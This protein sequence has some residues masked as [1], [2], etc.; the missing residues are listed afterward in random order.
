MKR[1]ALP[2]ILLL[3]LLLVLVLIAAEGDREKRDKDRTVTIWLVRHAETTANARNI[4][5]GSGGDAP[6]SAHGMEQARAAGDLLSEVSFDSVYTS[7]SRRTRQT[8]DLI[9]SRN[10]KE[11]ETEPAASIRTLAGLNDVSWGDAEDMTFQEIYDR[12]GT[13]SPEKYFGGPDDKD[14]RSP[15]GGENRY[16]FLQRFGKAMDGIAESGQDGGNILVV[17]HSSAAWWLKE[18]FPDTAVQKL[19]NA[20]VTK[21]VCHVRNGKCSWTLLELNRRED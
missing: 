16:A 10:V 18:E 5:E 2:G 1:K 17:A 6:L 7:T 13:F 21:L 4:A 19:D 8:A 3:V 9:L 12:Y 11:G 14:F 15:M 20:S